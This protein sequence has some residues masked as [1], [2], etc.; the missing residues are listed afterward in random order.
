MERA[1]ET[2]WNYLHENLLEQKIAIVKFRDIKSN[3]LFQQQDFTAKNKMA[4]KC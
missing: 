1:W 4:G 3:R 2:G